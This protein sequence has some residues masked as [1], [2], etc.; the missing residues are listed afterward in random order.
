MN[1]LPE[2]HTTAIYTVLCRLPSYLF[3]F[4]YSY[5]FITVTLIIS[6]VLTNLYI[7]RH[8]FK[9]ILT[10][11]HFSIMPAACSESR[12]DASQSLR[13]SPRRSNCVQ[14]ARLCGNLLRFPVAAAATSHLGSTA[15]PDL[16]WD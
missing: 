9:A 6:P 5:S 7:C 15:R 1:R 16:F 10:F 11:P 4:I 8:I 13:G 2:I 3:P 12:A 14:I